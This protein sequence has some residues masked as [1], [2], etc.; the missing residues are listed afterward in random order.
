MWSI[1]NEPVSTLSSADSYFAEVLL[2]VFLD[3]FCF[4]FY[5]FKIADISLSP[6]AALSLFGEFVCQ[7]GFSHAC[8]WLLSPD[9]NRSGSYDADDA[10]DDDDD[11]DGYDADDDDDGDDDDD[12]R[13]NHDH[14]ALFPQ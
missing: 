14:S 2:W 1:A 5:G 10:D 13:N 6:G 3:N 11:D 7:G 12:D 8:S 9:H 4:C